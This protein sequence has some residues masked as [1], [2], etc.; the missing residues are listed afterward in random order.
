MFLKRETDPSDKS[1]AWHI[2]DPN[3]IGLVEMGQTKRIGV[4]ELVQIREATGVV[5]H[6]K[7]KPGKK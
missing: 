7:I 6:R 4:Y 5:S 1:L 3:I 2:A